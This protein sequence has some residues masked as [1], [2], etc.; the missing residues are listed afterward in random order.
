[1]RLSLIAL[2]LL[3]AA[4]APAEGSTLYV[5]PNGSGS[6]C[7]GAAP[8]GSFAAAYAAAHPGDTVLV[9][10][11]NYAGQSIPAAGDRPGPPVV[12]RGEPAKG[13]MLAYLDV[14]GRQV[15]LQA[16]RTAGWHVRAG[17]QD[18]TLR[19]VDS[20]GERWFITSATNIS[21]IGGSVG[22]V[23]A[24]TGTGGAVQIKG[25]GD[26]TPA[27]AGPSPRNILID[28]HR[29]HDFTRDPNASGVHLD[30]LHV[31]RADGLT[32]R[33]ST[34]DRCSVYDILIAEQ[35]DLAPSNVVIENNLFKPMAE[36]Y[37]SLGIFGGTGN[38]YEHYLIRN[39]TFMDRGWLAAGSDDTHLDVRFVGNVTQRFNAA[40]CANPQVTYSHNVA[41][42][43]TGGRAGCLYRRG[44]LRLSKDGVP[45]R[46]SVARRAGA[47][48]DHPARDIRGR[49]RRGG[50]PDAGAYE[51]TRR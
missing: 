28:G 20:V 32:I 36:G 25:S 24:S 51:V 29:F 1:M 46:G 35:G 42:E 9:A 5:S 12:F 14:Y 27:G 49:S 41:Q 17:A 8:C 13:A 40:N 38:R 2:A 48:R 10:A 4:A 37:Y 43:V 31:F 15:E 33:N 22:P 26:F 7:T 6:A 39:N 45:G 30:C 34:F 47:P 44:P 18:V 16:L 23:R 50:R 21:V 11:G 3:L 19:D